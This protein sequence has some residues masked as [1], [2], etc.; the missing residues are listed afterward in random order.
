MNAL[1]ETLGIGHAVVETVRPYF[2]LFREDGF[3]PALS[4]GLLVLAGLFA[5]LFLFR[6]VL[7]THVALWRQ[8]RFI[9]RTKD[10]S[11]F[12]ENFDA[13]DSSLSRS[14]LLRHAWQEFKETLILPNSTRNDEK[15]IYN[16]VRPQEYFNAQETRL[17]FRFYRAFPNIFVG[18]GLLPTFFGLVWPCFLLHRGSLRE[19]ILLKRKMRFEI[20]STQQASSFTHRSRV[21]RH[22]SF[23]P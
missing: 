10:Y 9:R 23:C 7:P 11:G 12:V 20:F 21:L 8:T 22:R 19:P 16:T 1:S 18:V 6:Y 4:L 5:A 13:V 15:V 17:H 2:Q 14:R 3:A